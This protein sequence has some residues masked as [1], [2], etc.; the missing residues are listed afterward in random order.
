MSDY[1]NHDHGIEDDTASQ[2]VTDQ[3][4]DADSEAKAPL[5]DEMRRVRLKS[6]AD[7][8]DGFVL[9]FY[10]LKSD[11]I[12]AIHESCSDS[13]FHH[14]AFFPADS[15]SLGPKFLEMYGKIGD[16]HGS[17]TLLVPSVLVPPHVSTLETGLSKP[18]NPL[19]QVFQDAM[20][21]SIEI[22]INYIWIDSLC[23]IQDSNEDWT[24]E[25]KRMG[26]VY[27]YAACNIAAAGCK[28][29][30]SLGLFGERQALPQLHPPAFADCILQTKT[31][32]KRFHGL[33]VRGDFHAFRN[34]VVGNI[35]NTRA[36]VAQERALSPGI[37]HFTPEMIWWECSGLIANEALIMGHPVDVDTK[38]QTCTI[39]QLAKESDPRE[40]YR[41]WRNFI[42]QYAGK[43]LSHEKDRFPAAAGIARVLREFI[44]DNFIAGFWEGDLIRCLLMGPTGGRIED[45]PSTP[46]APSW[47]WASL[48]TAYTSSGP[49]SAQHFD[50]TIRP[51]GGISIRVL[52]DI[53]TFKSDLDSTSLESSDVR[54]LEITAPMRKL[55]ADRF[56]HNECV[57][58]DPCVLKRGAT[59]RFESQE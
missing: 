52:S 39:R 12:Y 53:P 56:K 23:I 51:L 32:A 57:Y 34:D 54:G 24:Y 18:P 42:S 25:A 22:G 16:K 48:R 46:R 8:H 33:Y 36:W 19:P 37:L 3:D 40:V 15:L 20:Y 58:G 9:L 5:T 47:S 7:F 44:D 17:S 41:V 6:F 26:D 29:S 35:L 50:T 13:L 14:M 28:D 2:S 11:A 1:E 4:E 27:Q 49:Q 45:I 30:S 31:G 38:L 43:E 10:L 59:T 21:V 55:P